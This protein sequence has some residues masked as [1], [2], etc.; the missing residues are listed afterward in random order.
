VQ[1]KIR[2]GTWLLN[3]SNHVPTLR[4]RTVYATLSHRWTLQ[5]CVLSWTLVTSVV[6]I[7]LDMYLH[8]AQTRRCISTK[9]IA[10]AAIFIVQP[11]AQLIMPSTIFIVQPCAQLIMPST[12][13]IVQ[14]CAQL[15]MPSTVPSRN[16][17]ATVSPRPA[18]PV[19]P[20]LACDRFAMPSI[21][22]SRR[23]ACDRCI[24]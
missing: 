2:S 21:L 15:I 18:S 14:P 20:Q 9:R 7:I 6:P 4:S 22:P 11:C 5:P 1:K 13:F 19:T 8:Y 23:S 12:I 16:T 10:S 17:R 24:R 3:I